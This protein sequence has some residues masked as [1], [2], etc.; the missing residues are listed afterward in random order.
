MVRFKNR[1][2][3]CEIVLP[4]QENHS[5]PFDKNKIY[6]AVKASIINNHGDYGL[7]ALQQ[8]LRV[9]YV[10]VDTKIAIIRGERRFFQMLTSSLVFIR[11][12]GKHDVIFRTL[13]IGG[14][15]RQC[16]KFL[17]KYHQK[18]FPLLY[19]ACQTEDEKMKVLESIVEASSTSA[20]S[21]KSS[22]MTERI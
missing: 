21:G 6:Q 9:N 18:N 17:I 2:A 12:V 11:K 8:S 1:Y 7:G 5:I 20:S 15:L 19:Q 3:L 16:Y 13:H 22:W 10:N 14:S 4:G